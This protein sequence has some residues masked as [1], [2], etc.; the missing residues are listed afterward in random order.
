MKLNNKGFSL[1]EVLAVVVIL[2]IL[3]TIMVPIVGSVINK[4]KEDNLNNLKKS[5]VSAAK[6]YV[7]D[8]RY[9]ISLE[10]S[11]DSEGNRTVSKI[12]DID[13]NKIYISTLVSGEYLSGSINNPTDDK[14]KLNINS[15]YISV[16]F[17]CKSKDFSFDSPYLVWENK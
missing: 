6:L 12:N 9:N 11:C 17:I 2:G 8:N 5:L 10:G 3:A 13:G 16:N 15:S 4:N 7:S 14:Q 1:V